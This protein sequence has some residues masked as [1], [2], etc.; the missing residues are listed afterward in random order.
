MLAAFLLFPLLSLASPPVSQETPPGIRVEKSPRGDVVVVDPGLYLLG[1]VRRGGE[2]LGRVHLARAAESTNLGATPVGLTA[3]QSVPLAE[4]EPWLEGVLRTHE[5][6]TVVP[7][8]GTL[9]P[10]QLVS[11]RGEGRSMLVT[12]AR[13]VPVEDLPRFRHPGTLIRTSLPLRHIEAARAASNLRP[14]FTDPNLES[15]SVVGTSN[16]L[17][18]QGFPRSVSTWVEVLKGADVEP[19][20]RPVDVA[21]SPERSAA[22]AR[23]EESLEGRLRRV[24]EALD[25]LRSA[26]R[27]LASDLRR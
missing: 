21:P 14:L 3:P 22:A 23:V 17:V 27:D 26:V 24:E 5:F 15:V 7:P 19:A 2:I 10:F 4:F 25:A 9:E 1:L 11:L 18:L 13:L 20:E 16:S 8:E 6:A 12:G